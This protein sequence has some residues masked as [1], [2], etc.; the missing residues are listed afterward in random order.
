MA[1]ILKIPCINPFNGIS[2]SL[3]QQDNL[4]I[5]IIL[6][7]KTVNFFKLYKKIKR[8]FNIFQTL[9]P[10]MRQAKTCFSKVMTSLTIYNL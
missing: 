9:N 6:T 3:I 8:I 4:K 10:I 7:P 1:K 2:K 5:L